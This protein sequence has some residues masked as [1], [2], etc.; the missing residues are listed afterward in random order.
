MSHYTIDRHQIRIKPM[1]PN[2][3]FIDKRTPFA[4]NTFSRLIPYLHFLGGVLLTFCMGLLLFHSFIASDLVAAIIAVGLDVARA[5]LIAALLIT[6]GSALLGAAVGRNKAGA[7]AGA[8]IT[9]SVIY[10]VDF[11]YTQLQPLR[12]PGGLLEPLN[13]EA[14]VRTIVLMLAL[15]LVSGFSGAAIG[16]S[17]GEALFDPPIYLTRLVW[18][19]RRPALPVQLPFP[20]QQPW[21]G[22]TSRKPALKVIAQWLGAGLAIGT[23]VLASNATNLFIFAPD[24]GI[25][26]VPK[27]R[28]IASDMPDHGTVQQVSFKSSALNG[29]VR[30]FQIYLPPSYNTSKGAYKSYPTLY[31]LHGSPGKNVDWI[32][33]GKAVESVDT[34]T[35]L[36][37]IEEMIVVFPDGN[38]RPGA[39]SEWGNSFDKRQ[40]IENYIA[41]D[42]VHYVDEH[43]RSVP[44]ASHRAIGGLSMGGFGAANI[45][46]HHPDIFGAF[47]SLGGYYRAEGSIWG[48]NP[49]YIRQN[50][51]LYILTANKLDSK[52][53]IYL[54]AATKDQPYYNYTK[55][56]MQR[57]DQLHMTY[58]FDLE[59]GYHSWRIW[60]T[61]LYNALP[62]L[63][64]KA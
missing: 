50:S 42:L 24:V 40:M 11:I 26:T 38:G 62:W 37:K 34:L 56:F 30:Q 8:C 28:N 64:W 41:N 22:R 52:L 48:K 20:N 18:Q 35:A 10:L 59:T 53:H 23:L 2:P 46:L 43:Y 29:Q 63:G 33:G 60:Q 14:L 45:T 1:R 17:L 15:G 25:H 31:L 39:T 16:K 57:L 3:P 19:R 36:G 12:D 55:E 32:T 58:H 61:Q 21:M 44:N 5:Q 49:A 27:V 7:I 47:I 9:Y 4:S 51:P 6:A 13:S 54:G